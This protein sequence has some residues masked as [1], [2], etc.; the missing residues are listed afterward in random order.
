[1]MQ[2]EPSASRPAVLRAEIA[3]LQQELASLE[4]SPS[5]SHHNTTTTTTSSSSQHE[6][7]NDVLEGRP[8]KRSEYRRYG[9]QMILDGF[10]LPGIYSQLSLMKGNQI[11]R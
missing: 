7:Q 1:M 3:R 11:K 8:L 4:P 9:R 2:A 10:G 6:V 5:R